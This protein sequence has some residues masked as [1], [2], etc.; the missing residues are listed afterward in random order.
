VPVVFDDNGAVNSSDL[1]LMMGVYR[2]T[3]DCG[4]YD[5]DGNATVNTS[6]HMKARTDKQ[7]HESHYLTTEDILDAIDDELKFR[8]SN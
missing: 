2:C 7:H 8:M 6:D 5:L 4:I 3:S 1:L